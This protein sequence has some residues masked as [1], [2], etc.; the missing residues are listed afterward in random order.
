MPEL[1]FRVTTVSRGPTL[2][3]KHGTFHASVNQKAGVTPPF[4][5]AAFMGTDESAKIHNP[6]PDAMPGRGFL[7]SGGG[8]PL[9]WMC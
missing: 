2:T 6:F 1:V 5:M 7:H 4:F 9:A 8:K 3:S